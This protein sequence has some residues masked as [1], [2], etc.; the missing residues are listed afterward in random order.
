MHND[1]YQLQRPPNHEN[2]SDDLIIYALP[3]WQCPS[4]NSDQEFER[5]QSGDKVWTMFALLG[6]LGMVVM[7]SL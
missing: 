7:L 4:V 3:H 5:D 2:V 6:L 1:D